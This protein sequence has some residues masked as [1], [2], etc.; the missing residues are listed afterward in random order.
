MYSFFSVF[1]YLVKCHVTDPGYIPHG[2]P[3]SPLPSKN[4]KKK[5]SGKEYK[6]C[7]TC[8]VWRIHGLSKHCKH[9]NICV[10]RFDHHC[11]WVGTCVAGR[12]YSTFYAFVWHLS[13]HI[14]SVGLICFYVVWRESADGLNVDKPRELASLC[15]FLYAAVFVILVGCLCLGLTQE[16]F[17]DITR[18]QRIKQYENT[19]SNRSVINICRICTAKQTPS[20]ILADPF[21]RNRV[22][23][24]E[25]GHAET[26]TEVNMPQSAV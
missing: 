16:V 25:S 21:F 6:Y 22:E 23:I 20:Y 14:L 1:F 12:N 2:T 26:T 7:H 24:D 5:R 11:P 3:E 19:H 10:S 13:N 17:N 9:C 15:I 8:H 18:N 4:A